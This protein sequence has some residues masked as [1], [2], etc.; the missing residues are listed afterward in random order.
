M[1]RETIHRK[2]RRLP[3]TPTALAGLSLLAGSMAL[4]VPAP[5]MAATTAN[6][7]AA[8]PDSAG[9]GA[10]GAGDAQAAAAEATAATAADPVVAE[11]LRMLRGEVAAPVVVLWLDKSGKRPAAVGS[12]DLVALHEA[13]AS[14]ELLKRLIQLA[15]GAAPAV[16]PAA[17][18]AAHKAAEAASAGAPAG[19]AK[20]A[21]ASVGAAAA[22]PARADAG[23]AGAAAGASAKV[24]P[25][26]AAS[27]PASVNPVAAA[28]AVA[29][30]ATAPAQAVAAAP[31][32]PAAAQA[33][34]AP[35]ATALVKTRFAVTYRPISVDDESQ[36]SEPWW[37]LLYVDGRVVASVKPAPA[38]LPLPPRTFDQ[39]LA[40]GRHLLRVTQERH[41]LYGTRQHVYVSRSRV[42]P[43]E[44]P[45]ELE[46][47]GA[48]QVT[49]HFGEKSF[50]HP[51]PIA[52]RVEREGREI[53]RL[54][55]SSPGAETWPAVC[56]D[57]EAAVPAGGKLP[58]AA[59]QDLAKCVHWAALWP[60]IAAVPARDEV[61]AEVE[62]L[63]AADR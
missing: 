56:E 40:P 49:V 14:D 30:S 34:P 39:E 31:P 35:S 23:P 27:P 54:E 41:R 60:G 16:A 29:P 12:G 2:S 45:F 37:L 28:A 43:S 61:R 15:G 53:A 11:V 22:A 18:A 44:F 52:V 42:D 6:A 59:R 3:V 8:T 55:P 62:R 51:G 10:A 32:A 21:A 20:A 63:A 9:D 47:G 50:R 25:S 26:P 38:L 48:A 19:P 1:V 36:I 58:S 7:A 13:G 57:V 17:G 46:P 5:T 33:P 24:A 4:A